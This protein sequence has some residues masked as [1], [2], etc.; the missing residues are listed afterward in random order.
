V[1]SVLGETEHALAADDGRGLELGVG[2][3]E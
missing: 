1:P 2:L 3:V